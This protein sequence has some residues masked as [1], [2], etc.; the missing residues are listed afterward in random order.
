MTPSWN[1]WL[2]VLSASAALI[3]AGAAQ[4]TVGGRRYVEFQIDADYEAKLKERLAAEKQ[5]GPLKDLVN[6]VLADPSKMPSDSSQLKGMDLKD[7][8]FQKA[9]KDWLA[10]DPDLRKALQQ[11]EAREYTIRGYLATLPELGDVVQMPD[12]F[13]GVLYS[14]SG[15]LAAG[16]ETLKLTIQDWSRG[17]A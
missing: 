7:A 17:I 14:I 6:Q 5:L 8:A 10:K 15:S 1:H 4:E 13:T 3:G 12:G 16:Q 2:F 9:L 11:F